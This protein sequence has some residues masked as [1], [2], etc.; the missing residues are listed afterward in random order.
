MNI[1]IAVP[2]NTEVAMAD[3]FAQQIIE[4]RKLLDDIFSDEK[5]PLHNSKHPLHHSVSQAVKKLEDEILRWTLDLDNP[6]DIKKPQKGVSKLNAHQEEITGYLS[7]GK[8][9]T[10]IAEIVGCARSTLVI[11]LENHPP[12]GKAPGQFFA[13]EA[14]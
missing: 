8:R 14:E 3:R 12:G 6:S 2:E 11:W 4:A 5:N 9:L 1:E 7:Q 13:D 10:D